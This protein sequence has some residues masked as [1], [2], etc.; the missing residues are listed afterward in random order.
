MPITG[1]RSNATLKTG[2]R[3]Q[4]RTPA[5]AQDAP[6]SETVTLGSW[7]WRQGRKSWLLRLLTQKVIKVIKKS[8]ESS[9]SDQSAPEI[10]ISHDFRTYGQSQEIPDLQSCSESSCASAGVKISPVRAI[11]DVALLL[12]NEDD[13]DSQNPK[14]LAAGS[15]RWLLVQ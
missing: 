11:L 7:L 12:N 13:S 2:P 10:T 1:C 5:D 4:S 6:D 14:T 9:K 8:S 3:G 15:R